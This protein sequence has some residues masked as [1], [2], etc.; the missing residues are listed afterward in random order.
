MGTTSSNSTGTGSELTDSPAGTLQHAGWGA[1][2]TPAEK[3]H[4]ATPSSHLGRF[5]P[6]VPCSVTCGSLADLMLL[7]VECFPRI[8]PTIVSTITL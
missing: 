6:C 3:D 7:R 1:Q 5:G 8:L 4:A 2:V